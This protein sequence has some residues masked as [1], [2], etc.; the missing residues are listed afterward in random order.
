MLIAG[1]PELTVSE[2]QRQRDAWLE[3]RRTGIGASDAAIILGI[4]KWKSP[5]QLFAEK[6]GL[7]DIPEDEKDYLSWG[8]RLEPVIAGAYQDETD[9]LT[10]DPGDFAIERSADVPFMLATIDRFIVGWPM[11]RP[12]PEYAPEGSSAGPA[13]GVLELKTANAFRR[14]EWKDEPPL[15]Y[16]IQLQHQ[17]A[18]T[19]LQWGSIAVLIG[20]QQFLWTDIARNQ[21]FIDA[22]IAAEE[23]F[24]RR[25]QTKEA[26]E[27][28]SSQSA[29]KILHALYPRELHDAT[30]LP[31][32]AVEW[33]R[34][35]TLAMEIIRT[36]EAVK[37]ETE[38]RIKAAMGDHAVGILPSGARYTWK[39][40]T[41][42]GYTV[43]PT[44]VRTLRRTGQ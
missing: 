7:A 26:P 12:R 11:D 17:L 4:S 35:R 14:E 42:A 29:T 9:R 3:E 30:D 43:A 39:S 13:R 16:Q 5:L 27:P 28:D 37:R 20:G 40:S 6:A 22:L 15:A 41:R 21:P 24:W 38:N 33:D 19:G 23:R 2:R 34:D 36:Q 44:S 31:I 25:V 10:L 1:R 32:E 8:H 18:V